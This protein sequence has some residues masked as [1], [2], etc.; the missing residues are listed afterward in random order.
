MSNKQQIGDRFG[1]WLSHPH[2][3]P[4]G[5][6]G[7]SLSPV[8]SVSPKE[9]DTCQDES[10]AVF[11][12]PFTLISTWMASLRGVTPCG[13]VMLM[14]RL[15]L[16]V[17]LLPWQHNSHVTLSNFYSVSQSFLYRS[18]SLSVS[19]VAPSFFLFPLGPIGIGLSIGT[20]E[21]CQLL[22]I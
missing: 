10:V 19:P 11:L 5:W 22:Y 3:H 13:L 21:M 12:L 7:V 4:V 20:V 1:C 8:A 18:L 14:D 6:N 2:W 15:P 9:T 17:N 16:P